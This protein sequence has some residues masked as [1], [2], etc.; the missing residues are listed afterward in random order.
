MSVSAAPSSHRRIPT[1][2][3]IKEENDKNAVTEVQEAAQVLAGVHA[4]ARRRS[5]ESTNQ[6]I[7]IHYPANVLTECIDHPIQNPL[8]SYSEMK[9]HVEVANIMAE[10]KNTKVDKKGSN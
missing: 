2:T 5:A 1:Y 7:H 8:P 9:E 4:A 3:E 10:I 6:P